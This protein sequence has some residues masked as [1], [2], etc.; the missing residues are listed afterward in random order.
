MG[1]KN[2]RQKSRERKK[3]AQKRRRLEADNLYAD[4]PR[5]LTL[6]LD[7]LKQEIDV[8]VA[9]CCMIVSKASPISLLHRCFWRHALQSLGAPPEESAVG[10][11]RIDAYNCLEYVQKLV[12]GVTPQGLQE[13]IT[14]E[15]FE[16]LSKAISKVY[17]PLQFVYFVTRS[18]EFS[19]RK[20]YDFDLDEYATRT[21]MHWLSVRGYRYPS[22]EKKHLEQVLGPFTD[23]LQQVYGVDSTQV[24]DGASRIL[25]SLTKG[26]GE[27]GNDLE[28]FKNDS[29][30][31]IEADPSLDSLPPQEAMNAVC[32]KHGW[33]ERRES[34]FSRVVGYGL[35]DVERLTGWPETL[36]EDLS[37]EPG[38]D[39]AF[40]DDK[41]ESGWP[42]R[43]SATIHAPFIR[44]EGASYCF[45]FYGVTDRLYRALEAGVKKRLL[46]SENRW[47]RAQKKASE[48]MVSALFQRLLPGAEIYVDVF[49]WTEEEG[50]RKR[51]EC[52][53]VVAYEKQLFVVEVKAGRYCQRPPGRH[54]RDHLKSLRD[55]VESA[56]GQANRLVDELERAGT[57]DLHNGDNDKL[58]TLV[59]EECDSVTRCCVTLDQIDDITAR[60]E[61][62]S[63]LNFD[64]GKHPVWCV[65]VNDLTTVSEILDNPLIFLDYIRERMR[66]FSCKPCTVSDELD[67]LGL[68]L[69]HNRYTEVAKDYAHADQ[70][71]WMG[72]RNSFDAYY[73]KLW[74]GE[75]CR[76]P[77]QDK[78][79]WMTQALGLLAQSKKSGRVRVSELILSMDS[80]TREETG[81]FIAKVASSQ[82]QLGRAKPVSTFGDIR[83][84]VFVNQQGSVSSRF[85][86][87]REH[88]IA[89]MTL[90]E[91]ED[92][93][94][95][96][97]QYS[98]CSALEDLRWAFLTKQD[99]ESMDQEVLAD[100][101]KALVKSRARK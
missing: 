97:L 42:T 33:L 54:L 13:N 29:L 92:R 41:P 25:H 57:L 80:K 51:N 74:H 31:A 45:G 91:E 3:A 101:V 78:E 4:L 63:K 46:K 14:D 65:S 90:A 17:L 96:W 32:E 79:L 59:S 7:E 82:Q 15:D 38:Q 64:I 23:L 53:L 87:S 83:L 6:S 99:A 10:P 47:N 26:I 69:E 88:A 68:Y 40:T 55:L 56:A 95:L 43:H 34:V 66:A 75:K 30:D 1:R 49:Y 85:E 70:I 5:L 39:A 11:D 27:A 37:L 67:H 22:Q 62:L 89:V 48:G 84:T 93:T 86:D 16:R 81:E 24:A 21:E 52:D 2:R 12:C 73:A 76:P 9:E 98:D 60:A 77:S 28:A 20:D 100:R 18:K 71:E 44:H 61:D 58:R 50:N 36:I 8:A 72:Y 94:L 19:K 35:F